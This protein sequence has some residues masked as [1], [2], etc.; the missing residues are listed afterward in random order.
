MIRDEPH[1]AASIITPMMLFPLTVRSSLRTWTVDWNRLASFT[2]SAAGRA[3][4]P[5]GFTILAER[6]I[7][8]RTIR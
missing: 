6:S 4:I 1:S 3:C 8:A 2:N 7:T 5:S